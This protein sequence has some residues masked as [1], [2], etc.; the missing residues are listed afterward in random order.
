[1]A[2]SFVGAGIVELDLRRKQ[3]MFRQIYDG[4]RDAILTSRLSKGER[5]PSSRDLA[6]EL[7]VSR[8]TVVNAYDQLMAEG[9]LGTR[10]GSGTFVSWDLP[11][12]RQLVRF[13]QPDATR[14]NSNSSALAQSYLSKRG[15]VYRQ[16]ASWR[17]A[18]P[19]RLKP[20][21]PGVP[22]L[23][24]FP[25]ET[26]NRICRRYWNRCTAEDLSYGE[27]AGYLPLRRSICKYVQQYRG[28]HCDPDQV[29]IVS[30]TQQAI[31][32]ASKLLL[33]PGD[34]VLFEDP[35]YRTAR[36]AITA[37]GGQIVPMPVDENGAD[38]QCGFKRSPKAKMTYVT[39]SHQYP[40]GVTMSIERRME[41]INQ[42]Q[43]KRAMII[44]DDYD[45]EYRYAQHPIPSLQGL[46]LA[47]Q[48]VYLGSF[49]KVICPAMSMG[50]AIVP[51]PIAST[52]S[53]A[54]GLVGRPPSR[55]N[56]MIVNEFITNGC[57]GRHLRRMRKV[58]QLR[59]QALVESF[60]RH[61]AG[62]LQIIGADAGLH[63]TARVLTKHNDTTL[64]DRIE[65]MGIVIRK[66]SAYSIS[67]RKVP[68]GLIFGFA[69]ATPHQIEQAVEQVATVF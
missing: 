53:A 59:R 17:P 63:C 22:A 24:E 7:K 26:W 42:A 6:E 41:L 13:H 35:G 8:M 30:G 20:F 48:T 4:I 9:Y 3:P 39:P 40:M 61:L 64:A 62:K 51:K 16:Q 29:M 14:A 57:F 54:L 50:Y 52:F 12:D 25:M 67:K 11:E 43:R 10:R 2:I 49:S 60:E 58:H 36:A 18:A 32:V 33:D 5:L 31:E 46:D 15:K 55:P 28:V 69:C 47:Q 38:I 27:P 1:M 45:S 44:E 23:D 66:L 65:A 19:D 34:E 56:Q 68:N 37:N 21:C